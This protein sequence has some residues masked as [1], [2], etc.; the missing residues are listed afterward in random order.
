[1]D[2]QPFGT[3]GSN[4]FAENPEPR[5]ACVL[6]LDVSGSMGG[7]PIRQLQEGVTQ[8]RD[9]LFADSLA[10]KR[11]EVSIVTFGGQVEEAHS[12]ATAENFTPPAL[13]ARGDTPM[14]Q[15]LLRG[16]ELLEARK[17]QYKQNGMQYFR[18]WLFLIT[19]GAPTDKNTQ[20][21]GDAIKGIKEG[22]EGKKFVFFAVG[23]EGAD[24]DTLKQIC[25]TREPLKLK[26]LRFR[27]LFSWLSASQKA[28]SR[29]NPGDKVSLPPVGWAE[30]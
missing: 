12:F 3:D 17:L 29:S 22:E 30:V 19:D 8:Y 15:A 26:G 25:S 24:F 13:Q 20:F 16:L 4:E 9:E 11:V 14:S 27:D 23:V 5:C 10:K 7:E 6:L 28:V 21:W 18:P 1:M 2:Q